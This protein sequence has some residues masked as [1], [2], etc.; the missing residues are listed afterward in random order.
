MRFALVL[1]ALLPLVAEAQPGL[2]FGFRNVSGPTT[3]EFN[4]DRRGYEFRGFY[5]GQMSERFGWRAELAG[6]QMQYRRDLFGKQP[7]VSESGVEFGAALRVD[8]RDGAL[9]GGYAFVGPI[10]SWR[11][12]CGVLGGFVDCDST[13]GRRVGATIGVGYRAQLTMRR[14]Y[15]FELKIVEG[16][17]AGAGSPVFSLGVGIQGRRRD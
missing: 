2:S 14:D 3:P 1:T 5:D 10:A 7:Q 15:V 9:A 13:S 8:Q 16:V 17:V 12:S 11:V 6:V 4:A